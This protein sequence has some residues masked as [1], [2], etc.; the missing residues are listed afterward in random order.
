MILDNTQEKPGN[1][2]K[3]SM[4]SNFTALRGND[5]MQCADRQNMQAP[6]EYNFF[7]SR[8]RLNMYG[9]KPHN[10]ANIDDENQTWL[11]ENGNF[12]PDYVTNENYNTLLNTEC[13]NMV[14]FNDNISHH[15]NTDIMKHCSGTKKNDFLF[16]PKTHSTSNKREK[17]LKVQKPCKLHE[18]EKLSIDLPNVNNNVPDCQCYWMTNEVTNELLVKDDINKNKKLQEFCNLDSSDER[19]HKNECIHPRHKLDW[20]PFKGQLNG[21]LIHPS[22]T[23]DS[24]KEVKNSTSF[25]SKIPKSAT[26]IKIEFK[27][28][29]LSS[30]NSTLTEHGNRC[31]KNDK[32]FCHNFSLKEKFRQNDFHLSNSLSSE[33]TKEVNNNNSYKGIMKLNSDGVNAFK[34]EPRCIKQRTHNRFTTDKIKCTSING[35]DENLIQCGNNVLEENTK[36]EQKLQPTRKYQNLVHENQIKSP[37]KVKKQLDGS[38]NCSPMKFRPAI[39]QSNEPDS[40]ENCTKNTT[41]YKNENSSDSGVEN[42]DLTDSRMAIIKC[43]DAH[44]LTELYL[45]EEG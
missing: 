39:I 30:E 45:K 29:G 10:T 23:N 18:F 37:Y 8:N 9:N 36:L 2:V 42:D 14:S 3:N 41:I 44:Y 21:N 4:L 27:T 25:K 28:K 7:P 32:S 12:Y 17:S 11:S 16:N 20:T 43:K 6:W 26:N 34:G 24:V 22:Q 35:L 38:A 40:A 33:L 13:S 1:I 31:D 5:N 15:M 19:T